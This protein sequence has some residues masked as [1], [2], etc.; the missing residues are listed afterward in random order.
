[1]GHQSY[2]V[3]HVVTEKWWP[4]RN[5][6]DALETSAG[7]AATNS[8]TK[9][10]TSTNQS[11]I[12]LST[13]QFFPR[14]RYY[15]AY[16]AIWLEVASG[17]TQ[18]STNGV[19]SLRTMRLL[20]P[21]FKKSV[22]IS[23]SC[24]VVHLESNLRSHLPLASWFK[25]FEV[26]KV[27]SKPRGKL[28]ASPT[29]S[30]KELPQALRQHRQSQEGG[31]QAQGRSDCDLTG[32]NRRGTRGHL[33]EPGGTCREPGGNPWDLEMGCLRMVFS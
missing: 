30:T 8:P 1:M 19:R 10:P 26:I 29:A 21:I 17:F 20:V 2:H 6:P 3:S 18:W 14:C 23:D 13:Y 16:L 15:Q 22:K 11:K 31:A 27:R 32:W 9:L 25:S 28:V 12:N 4:H 24:I 5:P 33:G 7:E